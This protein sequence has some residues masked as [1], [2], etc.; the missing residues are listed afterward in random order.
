MEMS[1]TMYDACVLSFLYG[2][3]VY[4]FC[5]VY[6]LCAMFTRSVISGEECSVIV[7]YCYYTIFLSFSSLS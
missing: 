5:H 1:T 4:T 6:L 2:H 7:V 3:C